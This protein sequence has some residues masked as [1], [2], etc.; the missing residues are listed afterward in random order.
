MKPARF[1]YFAPNTVDEAVAYAAGE[2]PYVS[3]SRTN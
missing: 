3:P 2:P 1:D